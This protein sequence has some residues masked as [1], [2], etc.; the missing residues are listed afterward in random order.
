MKYILLLT[1]SLTLLASPLFADHHGGS[2]IEAAMAATDRPAADKARDAN[3]KPV[4]T[5]AFFGLQPDM[6]VLELIPGGGWYTRLLAP[7][8]AEKG[9]LYAAIGTG[10]LVENASEPVFSTV[11]VLDIDIEVTRT[12]PH[13]LIDTNAY[14]FGITDLDMVLTFRNQ[15]NFTAQGRKHMNQAVFD[16]LASGGIYGVVDHTAR[17]MEPISADTRRR[18]DPVVV[19]K[20]MI[21][22]GFEFDGFATL[23]AKP[24]DDLTLE[25]GDDR[26]SGATDRFTLKFRKP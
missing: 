6:R 11:E 17:H 1:F 25:V 15:H 12:E 26:V 21:D 22:V 23:H 13:R 20:E 14:S 9:Q 5:L 3:R 18:L 16:A 2:A 19:I 7:V 4:E 24:G 8:L 10:N